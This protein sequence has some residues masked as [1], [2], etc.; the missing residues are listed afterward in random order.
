[1]I[2]KYRFLRKF[3]YENKI[4]SAISSVNKEQTYYAKCKIING[5]LKYV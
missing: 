2:K 5:L 4:K 3:M 1:M